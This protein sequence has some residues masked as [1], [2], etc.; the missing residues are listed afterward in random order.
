MHEQR[1]LCFGEIDLAES[2]HLRDELLATIRRSKGNL[3]IDF[4]DVTFL[5]CAGI[6]VLMEA[7]SILVSHG[8]HFRLVHV[9]R[10]PRRPLD[11]LGLAKV[12][13]VEDG[14]NGPPNPN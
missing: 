12:L 1:F 9:A 14:P 10:T 8:R 4:R 6:R 7:Q 11:V 5:D 3:T 2:A 13:R